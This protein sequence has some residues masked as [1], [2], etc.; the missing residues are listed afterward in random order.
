LTETNISI[1][2]IAISVGFDD[3]LSFSK[4]FSKY[5]KISP[6][7]YRKKK[8]TKQNLPLL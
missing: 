1:T 4:F 5:E 2:D 6:S 7:Q 8:Q 3:V